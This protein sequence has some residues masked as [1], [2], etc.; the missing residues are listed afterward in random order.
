MIILKLHDIS[1]APMGTEVA[2]GEGSGHARDIL[3]EVCRLG[4]KPTMISLAC[5]QQT[6]SPALARK[7]VE[8]FNAACL[9][10]TK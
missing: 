9:Q 4:L 8:W 2:L 1:A 10:L 6:N 7:S 5:A 3:G